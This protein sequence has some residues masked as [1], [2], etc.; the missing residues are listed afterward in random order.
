MDEFAAASRQAAARAL[1]EAIRDLDAVLTKA[2]VAALWVLETY[3]ADEDAGMLAET[4][5]MLRVPGGPVRPGKPAVPPPARPGSVT[6]DE[7]AEGD[8]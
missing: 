2:Q 5:R 3:T 6:G 1:T 4:V 7:S 8:R